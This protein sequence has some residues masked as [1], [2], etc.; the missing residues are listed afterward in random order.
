MRTAPSIVKAWHDDGSDVDEQPTC[1]QERDPVAPWRAA[2]SVLHD[3]FEDLEF[4]RDWVASGGSA[5]A[6]ASGRNPSPR[7]ERSTP[8][9]TSAAVALHPLSILEQLRLT[10]G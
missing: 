9:A 5:Q 6:L 10:A 4:A 7:P 1:Y 8:V 3:D 2:D